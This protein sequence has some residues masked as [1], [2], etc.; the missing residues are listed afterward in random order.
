MLYISFLFQI[1]STNFMNLLNFNH[2]LSSLFVLSFRIY[3][4][5]F[6]SILFLTVALVAPAFF[7]G[8]AG[9]GETESIVFFLSVHM[10]EAAIT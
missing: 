7:M 3:K 1:I 2:S 6:I 10:L 4:K 8:F 9:W 5:N